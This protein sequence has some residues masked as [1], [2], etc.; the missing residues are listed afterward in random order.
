MHSQS[1]I[2]ILT[3]LLAIYKEGNHWITEYRC[4]YVWW[5]LIT[6]LLI[7]DRNALNRTER[8]KHRLS[9]RSEDSRVFKHAVT[10]STTWCLLLVLVY[11]Y[12]NGTEQWFCMP[13][14]YSNIEKSFLEGVFQMCFRGFSVFPYLLKTYQKAPFCIINVCKYLNSCSLLFKLLAMSSDKDIHTLQFNL[15]LFVQIMNYPCHML[16]TCRIQVCENVLSCLLTSYSSTFISKSHFELI[17][18]VA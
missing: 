5:I 14:V 18:H 13:I 10:Q 16:E 7:L 9:Q 1:Q 11:I 12:M 2:H 3:L 8:P 15:Q 17:F 6:L 4:M